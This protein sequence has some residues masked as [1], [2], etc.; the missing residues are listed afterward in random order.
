MMK[1]KVFLAD[2][3]PLICNEL[4]YILEME[5]DLEVVG[6]CYSGHKAADE[7]KRLRPDIVFLDINMPGTT[8]MET[9]RLVMDESRPPLV[10]F[11]TAFE[12]YAIAAFKVNAV[13]YVLKPFSR[14]EIRAVLKQARERLGERTR[15]MQRDNKVQSSPDRFSLRRIQ[16]EKGG[17]LFLLDPEDVCVIIAKEKKTYILTADKEYMANQPLL[18]LESKLADRNFFRCHRNYL[19]NLKKVNEIIPWFNGTYLLKV[20]GLPK[21]EIPVSRYKVKEFKALVDL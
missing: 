15:H 4:R 9:A 11:V 10:I 8:G 14:E 5:N 3:E 16:G 1:Y 19:V 2:D 21:L 6:E 12:E 20:S 7:I 17:K 18:N 13:G